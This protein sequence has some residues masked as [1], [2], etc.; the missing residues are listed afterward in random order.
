MAFLFSLSNLVNSCVWMCL[1]VHA[2]VCTC[3]YEYAYTCL[4][5]Y[6]KQSETDIRVL[7]L[8]FSTLALETGPS[9]WSWIHHVIWNGWPVSSSELLGCVSSTGL[10]DTCRHITWLFSQVLGIWTH[11]P[12]TVQQVLYQL[13][14]LP[15]SVWSHR[16]YS[17]CIFISPSF[18]LILP[19]ILIY[20][21]FR[22]KAI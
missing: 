18:F 1:C 6:V 8:M 5:L 4:C 16:E 21:I 11:T 20:I 10:A 22:R 17:S 7:P 14:H 12:M 2:G 9:Q 15:I 3:K 19:F 13:G